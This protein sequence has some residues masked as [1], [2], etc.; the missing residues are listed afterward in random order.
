[1]VAH[2]YSA[3]TQET[4][5]VGLRVWGHPQLNSKNCL[6][7]Q[8]TKQTKNENYVNAG[9]FQTFISTQYFFSYISNFPLSYLSTPPIQ[10]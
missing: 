4:E 2:T 3:S 6:K 1:M 9:D 8:K 5:A 7:E 10:Q